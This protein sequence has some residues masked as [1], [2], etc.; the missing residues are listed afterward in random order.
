MPPEHQHPVP[1]VQQQHG[2][3]AAQP[4]QFGTW[5]DP[6]PQLLSGVMP[7]QVLRHDVAELARPLPAMHR[8]RTALLGDAAHPM[9]PNLGQ[10]G[11]QALEDAAVLARL[12][13]SPDPAAV[14]ALLAR[15]TAARLPR[16]TQVTRWSRRA[17]SMTT[18]TA[19]PAIGIRNTITLALGKLPVSAALRGLA[20][21]YDWQPPASAWPAG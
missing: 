8:G 18:W 13:A 2:H 21:V 11:C 17:A 20:Q 5:H 1:L 4:G 14:P 19:A 16:T 12:A 10:G 6:I 7:G 3:R 15:Y 9:T